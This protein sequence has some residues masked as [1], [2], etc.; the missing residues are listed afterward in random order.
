MCASDHPA[1]VL[2]DLR[3][4]G[5]SGLQA[6][7]ALKADAALQDIA[8]IAHTAAAMKEE[9]DQIGQI[10]DGYL[11]KPASKT[12]V[13]RELMKHLPHQLV[14]DTPEEA[15][16]ATASTVG[17]SAESLTPDQRTQLPV[18]VAALEEE[19]GRCKELG[20]TLTINDVEIF[21]SQMQELSTHHGSALLSDWGERLA[22]QTALFDIP[23]MSRTLDEYPQLVEQ[24]RSMVADS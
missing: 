18:L 21:A 22:T 12:D 16:V 13:V 2:M 14:E 19:L 1:L 9:E 10:F 20:Q 8:V 3:M 5:M 4:A 17:R 11:V 24:L 15:R 7:E 6:T 23:A